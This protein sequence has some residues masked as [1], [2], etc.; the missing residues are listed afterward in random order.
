[1]LVGIHLVFCRGDFIWYGVNYIAFC[2]LCHCVQNPSPDVFSPDIRLLTFVHYRD[3][4]SAAG[5]AGWLKHV[6]LLSVPGIYCITMQFD[7]GI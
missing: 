7:S 3:K 5:V 2:R 1:M 6:T 4:S